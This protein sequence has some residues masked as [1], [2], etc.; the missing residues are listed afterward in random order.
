MADN[1]S[2]QDIARDVVENAINCKVNLSVAESCTGGLISK[3]ITD[4]PGSSNCFS[5]GLVTYSDD[6]KTKLLG[7]NTEDLLRFGAVSEFTAKKMAERV[8]KIN[9]S[10]FSLAVTG[11][12][13]P[14]GG[15]V[16]KPVGTVW[17]AWGVKIQDKFVLE[18]EL[19]VFSGD[20]NEIRNQSAIKALLGINERI[21]I[22]KSV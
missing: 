17:I 9:N 11:I 12:A 10:D 20:R 8:A 2:M 5:Q 22:S 19:F 4:I 14:T 1:N 3:L 13:G 16:E 18:S 21:K 15:T 7:I 6:A